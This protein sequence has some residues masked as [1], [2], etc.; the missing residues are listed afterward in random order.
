MPFSINEH[1]HAT[2]IS[3]KG[4]FLGS[5]EREAFK[6]AIDTLKEAGKTDV[7][8]D[9]SDTTF[10]DSTGI[11]LLIGA[12]TTMRRAGGD[13]RLAG[14]HERIKNLF[15]MTRLLGSAFTSYDTVEGAAESF[16]PSAAD[17][18]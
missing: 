12:L 6:G 18:E 5:I 13:V 11:G 1:Y 17:E 3:L 7:V 14:M 9:L 10:M 8:I 4:R 15:L 2:V 16:G